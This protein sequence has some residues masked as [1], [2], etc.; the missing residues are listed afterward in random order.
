MSTYIRS[1]PREGD[2]Q[3]QKKGL[4]LLY[5]MPCNMLLHGM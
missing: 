3:T 1:V 5:D 4:Y 2:I